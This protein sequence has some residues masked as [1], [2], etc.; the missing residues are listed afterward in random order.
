MGLKDELCNF[1]ELWFDRSWLNHIYPFVTLEVLSNVGINFGQKMQ[2]ELLL[3]SSN[4]FSNRILNDRQSI[5]LKILLEHYKL[6][7]INVT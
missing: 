2:A 5:Q 7:T 4:Q 3:Q 1:E 6:L